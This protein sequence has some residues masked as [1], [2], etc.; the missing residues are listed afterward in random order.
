M[1]KER[2]KEYDAGS[3][4]PLAV[5]VSGF[6]Q[7]LCNQLSAQGRY[8]EKRPPTGS[9]PLSIGRAPILFVRQRTKGYSSAIDQVLERIENQPEFCGA[10]YSIV[11]CNTADEELGSLTPEVASTRRPTNLEILFGKAA[12]AEQFRIAEQLERH[13]AV[14]VQ[15]P[16]GTGKSHTIANLIGHLLANK[17][18]VLVTSH[19]TK[20]LRVLRSHVVEALR[21]LCVSVLENDAESQR[22]LR[23]SVESISGRLSGSNAETL[24]YNA[25]NI[26]KQRSELLEQM[27]EVEKLLLTARQSEYKP[28]AIAGKSYAPAEAGRIV[29][30][31]KGEYDWIPGPLLPAIG[32]P[33]TNEEVVELYDTNA[34]T[35]T[36]DDTEVDEPLPEIDALVSP[37]EFHML[38]DSG[39]QF[40]QNGKCEQAYWPNVQFKTT[41]IEAISSL[42]QAFHSAVVEFR[43]FASWQLAAV[44]SGRVRRAEDPWEH[45][46]AKIDES[47]QVATESELLVMRFRPQLGDELAW[48]EQL[49]SAVEIS[50]HLAGGGKLG[51]ASLLFRS[52]WKS[53]LK[54]WQTQGREPQTHEEVKAV[55]SLLRLKLVRRELEILWDGL[56]R[57]NDARAFAELG[58]SPEEVASQFATSLRMARQWWAAQWEP[59][60][61]RLAGMGF[62]WNRFLSEQSPDLMRYGTMLREIT[63]VETRLLRELEQ[64]VSWLRHLHLG[65]TI[66]QLNSR[67]AHFRRREVDGI[68]LA[69][70]QRD[71]EAYSRA[72]EACKLALE[73]QEHSLRRRK[74]LERLTRR[75][76]NA[77]IA[78]NWAK[79]ISARVGIH[80]HSKPPADAAKAWEWRQLSEEIDRRNDLDVDALGQRLDELNSEL[81]NITN[82][83]IDNLAWASQIRRTTLPQRQALMGWLDIVKR[84]NKGYG[85]RVPML[86]QEAQKK[87]EECRSAVPVWIMPLARVVENFDF[88]SPRF[89]VVI[90]DEA[91]QCDVMGLLALV[92]A[93]SVVVVGD[94]QQV[95]PL[96]VGQKQELVDNLIRLHLDG[97]PNAVLYDG[98]MSI[99]DL[100]K[101]AFAGV[102]RLTEHFRCVPDIIQFSNH[103]SY[104]GDIKPLREEASS[105]LSPAVV[106]IYVP[107]ECDSSNVNRAE[108][109]AIVSLIMAM[110]EDD[111]YASKSIGVVT[112]LGDSQAYEIASMLQH[113]LSPDEYERRRIICG[114]AS[115]FQGDE[116]DVVFLSVVQSPGDGPLSMYDQPQYRQR[117]NVAASRAKDQMW[118]VYSLDPQ[119]DLKPGD[120]RRRLIEHALDPRAITRELQELGSRTESPFEADVFRRL[121][122]RGFEVHPQWPVGHYRIDLVVVGG[123]KRLA[124]E[125]DGD[126][127]HPLEKLHEDMERQAILE[128]LGWQFIRIRGSSY[129]RDPEGCI[130]RVLKRLLEMSITPRGATIESRPTVSDTINSIKLKAAAL[131]AEWRP[132]ADQRE[133]SVDS[134]GYDLSSAS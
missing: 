86:R 106:P 27:A 120:L 17:K 32:I 97:I 85:K 39:E 16:P 74:L 10:L 5:E 107:G 70:E 60:L 30:K 133:E 35:T 101:Q 122:N 7:G 104:D 83:L 95:S 123:D 88:E 58:E 113:K 100:A 31:G 87:M 94:D 81:K 116:R 71:A 75:I 44:D 117:F 19:T 41:H 125:C 28:I 65:Q 114:N 82:R 37:A 134:E 48:E 77:A 50:N 47:Q 115:Q 68:R 99:Y 64:T 121:V 91:S 40:S 89:D 14:L 24:E 105:K 130:E 126:R 11:G 22:E 46:L 33:L 118:V 128:R 129:F 55:C 1:L 84:I 78:P 26:R 61:S 21:P 98:R 52:R 108:V 3:Y 63:A 57:A 62:D 131:R 20:A 102:I 23:H 80:G 79:A 76:G 18:S 132:P 90:I 66:K 38:C 59:L 112:L 56:M 72:F 110:V 45:L 92:M 109:E 6:L 4:H 119:T 67:L 25:N 42:I 69:L 13:K 15:G 73:R 103:L 49:V 9:D 111:A 8:V 12:N 93:K 124:I 51:F 2:Q 54:L 34:L 127:Y 96:A 36:Y 29:A 43:K 53:S